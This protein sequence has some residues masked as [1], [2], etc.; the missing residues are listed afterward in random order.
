MNLKGCER[1]KQGYKP[2]YYPGFR[3]IEETDLILPNL[4]MAAYKHT[5]LK[6]GPANNSMF[7]KQPQDFKETL[8]S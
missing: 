1:K 2:K 3:L 4:S 7:G 6:Q 5:S 8:N